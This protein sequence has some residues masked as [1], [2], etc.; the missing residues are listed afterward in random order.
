MCKLESQTD[1]IFANNLVEFAISHLPIIQDS[2]VYNVPAMNTSFIARNYCMDM[3]WSTFNQYIT[4]DVIGIVIF[5]K[6]R[7]SVRMPNQCMTYDLHIISFTKFYKPV[8]IIEIKLSLTRLQI[9]TF[10]IILCY[11]RI[12]V[13]FYYSIRSL[14]SFSYLVK[15]KCRSNS[16]LPLESIFKCCIRFIVIFHLTCRT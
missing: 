7:R 6:P 1:K 8:C 13:S 2:L 9:H 15:S 5:K 16:K 12:K 4:R 3:V 14:I 11:N 10:H